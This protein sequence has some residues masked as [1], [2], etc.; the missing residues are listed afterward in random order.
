[1][2]KKR[3]QPSAAEKGPKSLGETFGESDGLIFVNLMDGD[4]LFHGAKWNEFFGEENRAVENLNVMLSLPK[5]GDPILCI[6]I[7]FE[8]AAIVCTTQSE[9]V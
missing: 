3:T 4:V 6:L 1:M 2:K 9:C 5:I 8:V 7:G